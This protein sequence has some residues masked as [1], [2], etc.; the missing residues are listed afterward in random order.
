MF[1][2]SYI[3]LLLPFIILLYPVFIF[4]VIY[5]VEDYMTLYI[6][7]FKVHILFACIIFEISH[8]SF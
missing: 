4:S 2:L 5:I 8:K 1:V 7:N 3:L 6:A